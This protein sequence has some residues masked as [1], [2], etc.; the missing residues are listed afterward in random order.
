MLPDGTINPGDMTSFNHY[1]LGAVADWMHRTI[2]GISPLQPGYQSVLIA[3]IPGGTLTSAEA[4]V[5]TPVGTVA[6]SWTRNADTVTIN[7]ELPDDVTGV[8]RLPEQPDR[9]LHPGH[10]SVIVPNI[11]KATDA[12]LSG[13]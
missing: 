1:A 11:T 9:T 3:P 6:A 4:T 2:A 10:T 12:L 8:L 13:H 5:H 7:V